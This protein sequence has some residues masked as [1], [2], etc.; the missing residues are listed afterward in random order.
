M[1]ALKNIN[2][3]LMFG[4]PKDTLE[5]SLFDLEQALSLK[6]EHVSWYQLTME[7]NTLFY[8]QRPIFTER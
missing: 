8:R 4:L 3:D 6:P 5:G 1:L 2:I 7:P